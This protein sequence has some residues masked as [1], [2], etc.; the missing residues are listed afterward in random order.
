MKKF[1]SQCFAL[2]NVLTH[3][4]SISI[5][6]PKQT[7]KVLL[8]FFYFF[9]SFITRSTAFETSYIV[10]PKIVVYVVNHENVLIPSIAGVQ[11]RITDEVS[12]TSRNYT[13][14]N[15]N[16]PLTILSA[17][18][19]DIS[20]LCNGVKLT[21]QITI[22]LGETKILTFVF[23]IPGEGIVAQQLQ[24]PIASFMYSPQNPQAN[25][26]I[27]FDGSASGDPDGQIVNY[28]WNF[29]DNA[30]LEGK[31]V[32]NSPEIGGVYDMTFIVTDNDGLS[33]S[34]TKSI[35][36]TSNS[37][38]QSPHAE[39]LFMPLQPKEN[40]TIQ[41]DASNSFDTDGFIDEY[42][43]DFG[44]DPSGQGVITQHTYTTTGTY[45][46]KLTVTDNEGLI[47]SYSKE[48]FVASSGGIG[49][50]EDPE[51]CPQALSA[52]LLDPVDDLVD[53]S[54]VTDD[55]ARLAIGGHQVS[56]V[57][58][59]GVAQLLLRI[60]TCKPSDELRLQVI[61]DQGNPSSL[62][63]HDGGFL[64]VG[65]GGEIPG[66]EIL[67][68]AQSF[69]SGPMAFAVYRAPRDF[70]RCVPSDNCVDSELETRNVT[71]RVTR[72]LGTAS[73]ESIDVVVRVVRPPV[74]LLHGIW[75]RYYEDYWQHF[76]AT[77]RQQGMVFKIYSM[78][79]DLPVPGTLEQ[80][81]P[82]LPL[83]L[84]DIRVYESELSFVENA[85][86]MLI[87]LERFINGYRWMHGVAVAQAD[88][89]THSMGGLV[90][91]TMAGAR[92]YRSIFNYKKGYIHKLITIGTPHLGSPLAGELLS[93]DN[94]CVRFW[95]FTKGMPSFTSVRIN[96]QMYRGGV[97][98]LD[99]S[100]D[101]VRINDSLRAMQG[102]APVPTALLA[103]KLELEQLQEVGTT[104]NA[105]FL[106]T[107]CFAS[108]D[109]LVQRLEPDKWNEIFT[110][111]QSDGIVPVFSQID[112]G[113]SAYQI[114]PGLHATSLMGLGFGLPAE[115][116]SEEEPRGLFPNQT[117][118]LLHTPVY[119]ES[120]S[121][122]P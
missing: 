47:S 68:G 59:D 61:N 22:D 15:Y 76:S 102:A 100:G 4:I 39:F 56:G 111:G 5:P 64:P 119:D 116:S 86:P 12:H 108:G 75:A 2:T 95:F 1:Y 79:Y 34:I 89:V 21:Q 25:S 73:E 60:K 94:P 50:G 78:N 120:F 93:S 92:E 57:A 96:G 85:H 52:E 55:P 44:D 80:T 32:T 110:D 69:D 117:L 105:W 3:I 77:L 9:F 35:N 53:R 54:Y 83:L 29:E 109:P 45:L 71:V 42:F 46:V 17:G 122:I 74:L 16:Q 115:L 88:I 90:A 113:L 104:L 13:T 91:R 26:D 98:D 97:G 30:I 11:V 58:A 99:G 27:T 107:E 103:G 10:S 7:I 33:S 67:V 63:D 38:N 87:R 72:N 82:E 65:A 6:P 106:K 24:V 14:Q 118:R 70:S 36:V 41:F 121:E 20:V 8:F 51:T 49:D 62:A 84:Q 18:L 48:V 40:E 101:G 66:S 37:T 114:L 19:H 31:I 81:D 43:W 28:F 112:S 23:D